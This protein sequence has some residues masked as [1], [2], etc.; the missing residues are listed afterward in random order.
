MKFKLTPEIC[1]WHRENY[2]STIINKI[3]KVKVASILNQIENYVLYT[4]NN[5][6]NTHSAEVEIHNSLN[7]FDI[8]YILYIIEKEGFICSYE[9]TNYG[10]KIKIDWSHY[11]RRLKK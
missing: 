11:Y 6:Q 7:K 4:V 2:I 8:Q 3:D 9:D 5:G 10:I 1:H